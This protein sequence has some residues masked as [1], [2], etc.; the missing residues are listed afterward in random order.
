MRTKKTRE[1]YIN[2]DEL[3]AE[4]KKARESKENE[5]Y[6]DKLGKMLQLL[7]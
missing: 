2:P 6:S 3:L 4:V 1:N 7:T 5:A